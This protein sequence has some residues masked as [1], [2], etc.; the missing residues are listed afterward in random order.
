MEVN[1]RNRFRYE[2]A[3]VKNNNSQ[4]T[5]IKSESI[6]NDREIY[7]FAMLITCCWR[8]FLLFFL[9]ERSGMEGKM[10]MRLMMIA[11]SEMEVVSKEFSEVMNGM[12]VLI[13]DYFFDF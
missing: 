2:W 6:A 5:L 4:Y 9:R 8:K 3:T 11:L 10:L 13:G 12:W 7:C 1:N